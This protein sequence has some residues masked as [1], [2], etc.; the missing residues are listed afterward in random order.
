MIGLECI[1]IPVSTLLLWLWVYV[2][3]K[4]KKR[5]KKI[6][7]TNTTQQRQNNKQ[8]TTR[9][10]LH[11][12][13]CWN[14]IDRTTSNEL[15]E[16]LTTSTL[17]W[18]SIPSEVQC[19]PSYLTRKIPMTKQ[20]TSHTQ[21]TKKNTTHEECNQRW[22]FR[23]MLGQAGRHNLPIRLLLVVYFHGMYLWF[24][25][26]TLGNGWK[27]NRLPN[28]LLFHRFRCYFFLL[29]QLFIV[30]IRCVDNSGDIERTGR[31]REKKG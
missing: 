22:N 28:S 30:S 24:Y 5:E 27:K 18:L 14:P 25:M 16:W 2:D 4:W 21:A 19:L 20:M 17:V 31:K 15:N 26:R 1:C 11:A 7:T 8:R 9:H 13:S 29:S 10:I 6:I 23:S 3:R 12:C